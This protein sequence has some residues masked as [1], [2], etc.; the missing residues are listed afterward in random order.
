MDNAEIANVTKILGIEPKKDYKNLRELRYGKLMVM[1]DQDFD[2]SHIKGLIVNLIQHWWPSLY[3]KDGFLNEFVTPIVKASKK[4]EVQQFFS[5]PEY[6][7]WKEEN[8]NGRGWHI[9]YY[10]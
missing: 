6:E 3:K 2:G 4:N 7:Q 5:M 8:N 9:K 1:A 10:K